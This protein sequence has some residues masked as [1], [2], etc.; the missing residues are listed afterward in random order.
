MRTMQTE[1]QGVGMTTGTTRGT[2]GSHNE[3]IAWRRLPV[4]TL[5]AALGAVVINA[6][7]YVAASALGF[8][9][10]TLAIPTPGGMHPLTVGPVVTG[11]VV[12]AMGAAL[13]FALIGLV[14]RRPVR[15]FRIIA[16]VVLM[17]SFWDPLTLQSA[18]VAMILSLMMMHVVAWAV[19]VGLLTTLARRDVSA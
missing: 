11:S 18:P 1:M 8:I 3:G 2:R 9:S 17:L 16:T 19:S 5:L 15:L 7:I 14:A 13:V 12:G 4:V 6:I 10:R